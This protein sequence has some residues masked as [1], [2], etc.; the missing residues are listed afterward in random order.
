MYDMP[1][2]IKVIPANQYVWEL[3]EA[4]EDAHRFVRTHT[5]RANRRQKKFH[6]TSL[7]YE[8]YVIGDKVYVLF[9]VKKP[10]RSPK[11]TWF[12]K[13]QFEVKRK[14]C[15]FLYEV[16]CGKAGPLQIIHTTR[17]SKVKSQIHRGE[18]TLV[19]ANDILDD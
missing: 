13:G 5:E 18:E 8:T 6:D 4:M 3:Q 17:M 19:P 14:L 1:P 12:W 2:S 15:D 16:D 10:G 7:S 11:F 9:P